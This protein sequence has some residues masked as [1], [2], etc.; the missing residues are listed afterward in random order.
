MW[1][2]RA[3]RRG[4]FGASEPIAGVTAFFCAESQVKE[5]IAPLVQDSQYPQYHC[6]GAVRTGAQDNAWALRHS[7]VKDS[8]AMD[9]SLRRDQRA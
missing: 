8:Y 6:T 2:Y 7:A 3:R 1:L 9:V 4:R 5:S